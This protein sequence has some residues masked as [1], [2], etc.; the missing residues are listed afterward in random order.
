MMVCSRR[1]FGVNTC[2]EAFFLFYLSVNQKFYRERVTLQ[3]IKC[4]LVCSEDVPHPMATPIP[5]SITTL[6]VLWEY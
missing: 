5:I 1:L 4:P 2:M 3:I 6:E